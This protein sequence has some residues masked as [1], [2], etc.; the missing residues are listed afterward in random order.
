MPN[1]LE[2]LI[3]QFPVL[4]IALLVSWYYQRH[5]W[6]QHARELKAKDEEIARLHE[7]KQRELDRIIRERKQFIELALKEL[8]PLKKL[9]PGRSG[10]EDKT[11]AEE[12]K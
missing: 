1:W 4:A 11:Q 2:E 8:S 10:D 3:R 6:K 9:P 12:Q 7:E 5:I